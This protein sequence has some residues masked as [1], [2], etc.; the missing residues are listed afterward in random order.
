MTE[1]NPKRWLWWLLPVLPVILLLY[2]GIGMGLAHVIDDDPDYGPGTLTA[3]ESRAVAMAARLILREVDEHKWVAND[4]FFNPSVLLD[5]MPAYQTGIVAAIANF[6]NQLAA[7]SSDN[8][9]NDPE[10]SRAAGFLKYPGTI[11]KFDSRT[12]WAPT[13]SSEKQYRAAARNLLVYNE[14]LTNGNAH[15]QRDATAL[16]AILRH[17]GD[18]M[19]T[20][21]NRV[22]SH[23]A[24]PRWVL[25]D[26]QADDLFYDAKG[27]AY[28]QSLIL[29]E[30]GWDF[31]QVISQHN[32]GDDWQT[33]LSAL[34]Q[35]ATLKP[36][37]IIAGHDDSTF[38]PNHLANQGFRLLQARSRLAKV[39]AALASR[40]E[41]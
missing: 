16:I 13:A 34:R 8:G 18:A 22:D 10:L 31:A 39:T 25:L 41:H 15:A 30:L 11:W 38:L 19:D 20:A 17:L 32:L 1:L 14:R 27:R 33:M 36:L 4:P 35:A 9:D 28:A 7:L 24:T 29:R 37:M 6:T 23:L 26:S 40:T 3:S 12:S 2:Y 5:D 21:T